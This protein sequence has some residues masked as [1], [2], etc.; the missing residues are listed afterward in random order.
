MTPKQAQAFLKGL[1]ELEKRYAQRRSSSDDSLEWGLADASCSTVSDIADAFEAV[2]QVKEPDD[3][4][5]NED[6]S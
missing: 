5:G 4:A 1:R 6:H 2:L 3:A